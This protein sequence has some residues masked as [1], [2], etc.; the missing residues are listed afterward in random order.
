MN[1]F[2]I[3]FLITMFCSFCMISCGEI[4]SEKPSEVFTAEPLNFNDSLKIT[5]SLSAT[6]KVKTLYFRTISNETLLDSIYSDFPVK[7]YNPETLKLEMRKKADL[8]FDTLKRNPDVHAAAMTYFQNIDVKMLYHQRGYLA[9]GYDYS[10]FS[11]GAHPNHGI[12]HKVFDLEKNQVVRL[13]DLI[14]VNKQQ[15]NAL[16]MKNLSQ[17]VQYKSLGADASHMLLVDTIPVTNNFYF[18]QKYLYFSYPPYEIAPYYMGDV[19]IPI[20]W[21]QLVNEIKPD[22]RKRMNF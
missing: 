7:N 19:L 9:L 20:S 13:P 6:Y 2:L 12:I 4:K 8:Y 5:D 17:T 21:D 3:Y 1:R 18:D 22:F 11:G 10:E 15:I 16:L 14:K